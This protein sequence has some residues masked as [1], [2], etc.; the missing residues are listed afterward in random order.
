MKTVIDNIGQIG[1]NQYDPAEQNQ[2]NTPYNSTRNSQSISNHHSCDCK[3]GLLENR[4]KIF[5]N[6]TIQNMCINTAMNTQLALQ[7]RITAPNINSGHFPHMMPHQIPTP[8]KPMYHQHPHL[9]YMNFQSHMPP[10]HLVHPYTYIPHSAPMY[11]HAPHTVPL[12]NFVPHHV[13]E[14]NHMPSH[15]HNPL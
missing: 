7:M 6:Q 9:P 5:E 3:N 13:P 2:N 10:Q 8:F 4:I 11:N 15:G 1:T 12:Q 14:Y